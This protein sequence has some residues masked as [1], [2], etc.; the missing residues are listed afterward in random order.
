MTL[1]LRLA[2]AL[3]FATTLVLG[4][5]AAHAQSDTTLAPATSS[6]QVESTTTTADP[7]DTAPV[8]ELK[9]EPTTAPATSD[10]GPNIGLLVAAIVLPLIGIAIVAW[11]WN[12]AKT[13]AANRA[14]RP[15]PDRPDPVRPDP[16]RPDGDSPDG[17]SPDRS[18]R[19]DGPDSSDPDPTTRQ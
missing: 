18:G 3:V 9:P 7:F 1:L 11:Y 19:P 6:T 16:D 17:D 4:S 5:S 14:R 15:A 12:R 8:L 2:A 13:A 10:D